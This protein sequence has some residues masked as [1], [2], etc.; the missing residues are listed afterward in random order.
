MSVHYY[1]RDNDKL[2]LKWW[3][4]MQ[5][6]SVEEDGQIEAF[7][8]RHRHL[9]PP[10]EHQISTANYTQENTIIRPESQMN[11]HITWF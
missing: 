9:P 7:T 3:L 1:D 5:H 11:N 6:R 4:N 2:W 8:D 10:L